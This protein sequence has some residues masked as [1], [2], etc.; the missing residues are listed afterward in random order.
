MII[1]SETPNDYKAIHEVQIRYA[2]EWALKHKSNVLFLT[3]GMKPE[4]IRAHQFYKNR[5][6]E[7]TGY[8]FV[9][10]LKPQ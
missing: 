1:R 7:I 2:E 6:F 4:R 10:K 9:K 8:R 3:S 5:G